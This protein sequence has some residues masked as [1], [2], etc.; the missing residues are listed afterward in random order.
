MK[1][2]DAYTDFYRDEEKPVDY[3]AIV[4]EYLLH[5]PL[6]LICLVA[7]VAGAYVYLRYQPP[8]YNVSSTLL[9]KQ[10]DKTK[11]GA[12][13]SLAYMQDLGMLSMANNFDNEVEI[14]QSYT[15]IRKVVNALNLH[16]TYH[17]EARFRY[18]TELYK[19]SPIQLWMAPDEAEQL[20]SALQVRL[21]CTPDGKV[22]A[23]ASFT[24]D[25]EEH[26]VS[27]SFTQL[28]A[29]LITPVGT[30]SLSA[31]PDSTLARIDEPRTLHATIVPPSAM[32][33]S[34][35]ARLGAEPTGEFTSI[36]RLSYND[37]NVRR[38]MDF[39][40]TLVAIYNND[41]NEDKNQVA[42][43]TAQFIDERIRIINAELGTTE[44]QL[45]D[46]KQR[47]GLTDLSTDA[48]M[49]LEE[50]SEYRQRQA[51]NTTQ[52]RLIDFLRTY[53]DDPANRYEVIPANVG[54]ADAGLVNVISQY[55]EMLI[56]RKR[57][58]RTSNEN[59]PAV[60]NL[61]TSIAATRNTVRT[62]VEN[63]EKALQITRHNLDLEARKYQS[64]VSSA[65][66]QERELVSITRQQEIKANLYLMLLQKREE[67][68]IT[69]AAT[70][71][72]GRVVEEPMPTGPVSPN[73]R[74]IYMVAFV[75][76]LAFP[77]GGI[78]LSRL[79]RFKI[80]GRP[81][82][83]RVTDV[84]IVGDI[85]QINYPEGR[86]IVVSENKNG[87]MEEVFRNVRT[88]LQYMLQEGQKVILF[89][90]T[91]SGE[92]KSF[93]AANL[94]ASFAFMERKTLIVGLDIRKPALNRLFSLSGHPQGITQY[95]AS[96]S[97]TDLLSLCLPTA[98]SPYLYVLPGG[99]VPPNPTELVARK[100]L[101]DAF[102]LLRQH[103]DYIIL[104]TAPIGVVTDTRLIAR[105][106]DLCV[107]ICRADYTHKSD[108]TFINDLKQDPKL[109]PLCTLINGIDMDKR[110]NG[111]YYG[112]GKYGKYGKYGYG[113][114]YGYGYGYG[115]GKEK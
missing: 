64:R 38:G 105:V 73:R 16:I 72:N 29:V 109:P 101:D 58:L 30:L 21:D 56:E 62:T 34:C 3:K 70:A 69:L 39:L 57:L 43:R 51:D 10:G 85:P 9:I 106:A 8:V 100:S 84:T 63:V 26:T 32:A 49:A 75:L 71:N 66:Q 20:P 59:N 91:T 76:G 88:N 98:L 15:L 31:A 78:Y 99:A 47:A 93:T 4:F 89:T 107:Y 90:S 17:E 104:D 92:G 41:A 65:P 74:N 61:D 48:R 83:E 24:V 108:F 77:I 7:F 97:G 11:A 42:S 13:S 68:A 14:L 53:I 6:I 55:N 46:Y 5:W 103:F 114:K 87:L 50:S 37:T 33:G 22:D 67:N 113:K 40:N 28:P 111:Y 79:L 45:A 19:T 115:Y 54:I 44:S 81:D 35:K 52:L 25:E 94:A 96:P 18:A 102:A 95:L 1:K 27:K 60:V 82:V 110:K 80:E 86:P 12:G 112:Y 36:V 23:T 2:E